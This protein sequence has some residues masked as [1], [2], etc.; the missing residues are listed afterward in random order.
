M[1]HGVEEHF[2]EHFPGFSDTYMRLTGGRDIHVVIATDPLPF[3]T[4]CESDT[5][6]ADAEALARSL[7]ADPNFETTGTVPVRIAGIDAMQMDVDAGRSFELRFA[8]GVGNPCWGMWA[9]DQVPGRIRLLLIDYPGQSAQVLT[10]AVIAP[11]RPTSSACS[12]RR[13]PSWSPSRSI[14]TMA[15]EEKREIE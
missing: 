11:R 14:Q 9:A 8:A 4:G 6:P 12:R 10:I 1:A 5:A 7:M 15:T 13:H 3:G 2:E